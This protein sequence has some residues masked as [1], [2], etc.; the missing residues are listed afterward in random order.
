MLGMLLI[1]A[2]NPGSLVLVFGL[3]LLA[4]SRVDI[5]FAYP[6][7]SVSYVVVLI[8]G[9]YAFGESISLMRIAGVALI[10]SYFV[11]SS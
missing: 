6:F 9:H 2:F 10:A 1:V 3:H 8:V 7:L 4:L 11:A 5:S